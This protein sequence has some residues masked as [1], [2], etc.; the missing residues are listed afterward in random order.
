MELVETRVEDEKERLDQLTR[1]MSMLVRN[2]LGN[3]KNEMMQLTWKFRQDT[4][5][6]LQKRENNLEK[7]LQKVGFL[8]NHYL[9]VRYQKIAGAQYLLDVSIPRSMAFRKQRL[10]DYL[11]KFRQLSQR[12][13][14]KEKHWMAIAAQ[15]GEMSDPGNILKK[16]Y[17]IT[18]YRG[19][20]VKDLSVL[21]NEEMIATRFYIGSILSK[22]TE[23]NKSDKND[24]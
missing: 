7:K 16:G 20:L 5:L 13:L 19:K 21:K 11:E 9:F 4:M 24:N 17:S 6:S 18:T 2:M 8:V 23:I 1:E 12:Q 15:K 3:R 22:I 10:N 14:E